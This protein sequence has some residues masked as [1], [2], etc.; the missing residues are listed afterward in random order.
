MQMAILPL[1][2][3]IQQRGR[4]VRDKLKKE[5]IVYVIEGPD[6]DDDDHQD[7]SLDVVHI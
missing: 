7:E 4:I 2:T 1:T 6:D 5:G 3:L